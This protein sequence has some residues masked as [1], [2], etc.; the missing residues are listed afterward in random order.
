VAARVADRNVTLDVAIRELDKFSAEMG[1]FTRQILQIVATEYKLDF[2]LGISLEES[3][4]G[5][6]FASLKPQSMYPRKK[7]RDPAN[8]ILMDTDQ[9]VQSFRYKT[10]DRVALIYTSDRAAE[11]HQRGTPRMV[12]RPIVGYSRRA[13]RRIAEKLEVLK[14]TEE[15][16]AYIECVVE[17]LA[18]AEEEADDGS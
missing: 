13:N 3:P 2:A 16:T 10:S 17:A 14:T 7:R 18:N 6:R 5:V 1:I 8:H 11:A 12:P 15:R 4:D 9:L